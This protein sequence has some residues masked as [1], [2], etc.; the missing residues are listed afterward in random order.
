M[1]R[2]LSIA[3][4]GAL[5]VV[6]ALSSVRA[7]YRPAVQAILILKEIES[8]NLAISELEGLMRGTL[9][10]GKKVTKMT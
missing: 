1:R 10:N 5:L 3:F 8:S 4:Y 9:R 2:L 7:E 6:P